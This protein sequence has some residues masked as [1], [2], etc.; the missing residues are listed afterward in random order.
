MSLIVHFSFNYQVALLA[1]S[2]EPYCETRTLG[3][4]LAVPVMLNYK[5]RLSYPGVNPKPVKYLEAAEI[6]ERKWNP[7]CEA[8]STAHP[9]GSRLSIRSCSH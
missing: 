5:P 2:G 4:A 9:C 6:V 3:Q 8:S 7:Y 1:A